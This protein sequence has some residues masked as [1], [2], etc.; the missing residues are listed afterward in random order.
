M[1]AVECKKMNAAYDPA[2]LPKRPVIRDV[3]LSV[4]E[5]RSVAVLGSNGSGKSTLLKAITG[6]I[7]YEGEIRLKERELAKLGRKEISRTVA[8]MSQLSQIFF[9]YTVYDTVMMGRYVHS[10]G[11]FS[12]HDKKDEEAVERSLERTGIERLRNRQISTLS[13]GELQRVFLARTF[14]QETPILILDEPAN[15]LDLKVVAAMSVYLKQWLKEGGHTLIGVYHD[16]PL[17]LSLADEL[18]LMKDGELLEKGPKEKLL[19]NG[20]LEKTYDFEVR[21]YLASLSSAVL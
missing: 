12:G 16:I 21:R 5:G 3:S 14:A 18:I 9:S 11:V 17:A 4:E 8:Y 15:H 6:M 13:G 19:E 10:S 7:P 1:K 20:V 2:A